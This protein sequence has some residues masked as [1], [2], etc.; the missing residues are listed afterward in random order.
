MPPWQTATA[1]VSGGP[2]R[3]SRNPM[4]LGM[5]LTHAGIGL[6]FNSIWILLMLAPVVWWLRTRVIPLEEAYMENKFG[7]PYRDYCTQVRR[8]F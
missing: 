3:L 6:W 7:Q 2:Y 1:V 8:W 5:A 4:Y